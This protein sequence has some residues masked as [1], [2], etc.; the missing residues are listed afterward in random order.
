MAINYNKGATDS[1]PSVLNYWLQGYIRDNIDDMLPCRVIS[2]DSAN[3]IVAVQA[4]V[5]IG[6][7]DGTKMNRPVLHVPAIRWGAGGYAITLPIKAD[8]FG[9]LKASDRDSTEVTERTH[10]FSDGVFIPDTRD[11][12]IADSDALCIQSVDG[13]TYI[14]LKD[15]QVYIKATQLLIEGDTYHK[16]NVYIVAGDDVYQ[17]ANGAFN[18]VPFGSSPFS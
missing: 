3:N 13:S 17:Y 8:D 10:S 12:Q 6:L 14:T 1:L 4:L 18:V 2:Y 7:A 9:W 15:N 5:S 11:V 16:G